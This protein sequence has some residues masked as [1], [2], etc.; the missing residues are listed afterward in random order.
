MGFAFAALLAAT[1]LAHGF[2][3]GP[4]AVDAAQIEN[5]VESRVNARVLAAI[6]EAQFRQEGEFAKVLNAKQ[7]RFEAHRQAALASFQQV[8]EYYRQKIARLV[9]ASNEAHG[10]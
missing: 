7:S 5:Q 10:K 8:D 4:A 3:A 6:N 1:L 9:V 2:E